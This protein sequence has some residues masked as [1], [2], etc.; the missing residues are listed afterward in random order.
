MP[1][2][3][4]YSIMTHNMHLDTITLAVKFQVTSCGVISKEI[5]TF[6]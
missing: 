1:L 2:K 3:I 5:Y 4:V 6:I